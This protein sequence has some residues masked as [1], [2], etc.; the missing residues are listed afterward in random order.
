MSTN[1]KEI[2]LI[3]DEDNVREMVKKL[4]VKHQ[5]DVREAVDGLDGLRQLDQ[6]HPDLIITDVMMPNLDGLTLTKALKRH[7]DT[8]AIPV[9]FLTAKGDA[10]SMIE[11]INVGAKYYVTKPF[12]MDDLL[13]KVAKV[14]GDKGHRM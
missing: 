14:I 12:Q 8:K 9:I 11:G 6:A 3:E 5:F 4:L 1:R 7:R 2:L 13:S 10:R